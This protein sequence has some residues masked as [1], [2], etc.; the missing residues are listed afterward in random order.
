M[1][2]NLLVTLANRNYIDQAKQ[3]FSSVYFNAGWNGDYM[4][5]A[6]KIPEKELKWF[7]SKGI[8]IKQCN[9]ICNESNWYSPLFKRVLP[10]IVLLKFYL[11]T[12]EFRKWKN[13]IYL[14]SDIIVKA[15]LDELI[16]IKGFAAVKDF[17]SR[18]R[19]QFINLKKNKHLFAKLKK[20]FNLKTPLFNAG[21]MAFNTDVIEEDTFSK[22]K[23]LLDMYKPVARFGEQGILN[24]LFYKKWIELPLVY[25]V[26]PYL[27]THPILFTNTKIKGII[28]HF[29]GQ[30]KPWNPKD[31]FYKEWKHNLERAELIDINKP[32]VPAKKWVE[33][34]IKRHSQH[35]RIK[36]VIY[37]PIRNIDKLIGIVGIF[38]RRIVIN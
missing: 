11:F 20:Y 19:H 21:V 2:K 3:L 38:L 37:S 32:A 14:D 25:N 28:L 4:L 10:P 35:L 31:P 29:I 7:K 23:Q 5:L 6:H 24:L 27:I 8:L 26:S 16:N 12:P 1:K 33:E 18:L 22:L 34:E 9:D 30:R 17:P 15:S 13:I 36:R